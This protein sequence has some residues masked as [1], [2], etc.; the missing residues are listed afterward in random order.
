MRLA[1]IVGKCEKQ[2]AIGE[3]P[4][5]LRQIQWATDGQSL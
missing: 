3:R 4:S 1:A 2:Y 5:S